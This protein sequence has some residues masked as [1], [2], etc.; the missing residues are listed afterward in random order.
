MNNY[1]NL[2][3]NELLDLLKADQQQALSALYFRYWDKLLVVAGNR[4]DNPEVAEECVQ[5]VFFS[6]WQRRNDLKLKYSLATYLAVAVKY[7]VIKQLD[8]QYRLQDRKDKSLHVSEEPYTS[9]ADE[10]LLEKELMERIEAAVNRLPEK[11]RIVFKLSREQ[12][13]T[14]KQIAS[15]LD[16][17]EKT[18]EAHLSKA[19]KD[20]RSDLT[21]I[22]P[23]LLLWFFGN[24][25]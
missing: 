14:N 9:S 20:L 10:H 16:I 23:L 18:V 19:I 24:N 8:K 21:T 15:D 4:L 2:T 1:N 25:S 12:G 5:D 11:C 6:L 22:S 13:M 17:S 7:Q 3:D